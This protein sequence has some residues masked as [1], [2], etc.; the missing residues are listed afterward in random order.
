MSERVV[1]IT[2]AKGG[3]GSLVTERFLA[4]G[5]TVVGVSR[6]ISQQ[7]FPRPNFEALPVDFTKAA[8]VRSAI[9]SIVDR[10]GRLDVF[11]TC[12]RRICGRHTRGGNGRRH[13][14]TDARSESYFRILC[15]A[16]DDSAPAKIRLRAHRGHRQPYGS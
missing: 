14:G 5:A 11:G 9:G 7:D 12:V 10:H 6:S 8:A 4:S 1:L 15:F 13:L 16:G 3:L 2:G